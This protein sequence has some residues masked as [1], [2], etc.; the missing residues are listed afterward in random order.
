MR[1]H[2][3]VAAVVIA[4]AGASSTAGSVPFTGTMDATGCYAPK[5]KA[6]WGY[7]EFYF[8]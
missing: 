7:C 6:G 2:A 3:A 4:S 1:F 8:L 5:S